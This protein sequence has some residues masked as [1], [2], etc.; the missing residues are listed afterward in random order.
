[1]LT[2]KHVYI[3][4]LINGGDEN[5][6]EDS[7]SPGRRKPAHRAQNKLLKNA[8]VDPEACNETS[9]TIPEGKMNPFAIAVIALFIGASLVEL[10]SGRVWMAVFYLCSAIINIAAVKI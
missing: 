10:L 3:I 1:M 2:N 5:E 7:N 9:P 8:H 6:K 4:L